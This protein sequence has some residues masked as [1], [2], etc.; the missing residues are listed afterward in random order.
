MRPLVLLALLLALLL[1]S[2]PASA[3]DQW[4]E[5][6]SAHFT[7]T[8]NAGK[9]PT[10]T[11]AWQLEQMRSE[12][13]VLWPWAKLDL[14]TPLVVFALKDEASLKALAP[15]Y[16]EGKN[17]GNLASVWVSGH[18]RTFLALRTDIEQDAKRHVNPYAT[19][20]FAYGSLVLQQSVPTRLPPWFARGL[21][22]VVSNTVIQDAQVLFGAPAPWYLERLRA[23]RHIPLA[24]LVA[25]R[26]GSPWLRGDELNLFD[27][28][29]WALV[30]YLL[31]ADKAAH[32]DA[33]SRYSALLLRG[34]DPDTAFREALGRPADLETPL[35]A[36]TARSIFVY[37]ALKVDA[38][39]AREKFTA[40]P[41][42]PAEAAARRAL[43][44]A[45][46]HRPAETRAAIE[47]A[48]KAGGAADAEVANAL[49]LDTDGN[50]DAAREAF[51]RAVGAGTS[52]PYAYY[53]LASLTWKPGSDH[54]ALTKIRDLLSKAV[55]FNP[56]YAAAYDFLASVDD[57][58]QRPQASALAM[59]AVALE[60]ASAHHHLT[61]ARLL[62]NEQRYDDA[63][64]QLQAGAALADDAETARE[65]ATLRAW[66]ERR[67]GG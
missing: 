30:H 2:R 27:A 67:K 7:I 33:L 45:T 6:Q 23:G 42:T 17:G 66:I 37:A 10:S 14:N 52:D 60:P 12:M 34:T 28:E 9:G 54:D 22:A 3:A 35:A 59:R 32:A 13:A 49:V 53:R 61:A 39:V 4:T 26:N 63:L 41:L 46:M 51:T 44:H 47:E 21:A 57:E 55:S 24:D 65:A 48:R 20:Y 16:W 50:A 18:D 58:L 5:V 25:A 8:S 40:V 36:Y 62:A 38:S 29:S 64:T 31:F 56:R 19:S 1:A 15:Q 11:L 43:F